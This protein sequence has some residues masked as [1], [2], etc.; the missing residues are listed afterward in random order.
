MRGPHNR[1][2]VGDRVIDFRGNKAT[3]TQTYESADYTCKSHRVSVKWDNIKPKDQTAYYEEVFD[4]D[5]AND[6]TPRG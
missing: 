3:V 4:A 6:S 5:V 2:S 1:F